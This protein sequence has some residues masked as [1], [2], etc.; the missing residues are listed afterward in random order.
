MLLTLRRCSDACQ[1]SWHM[2]TVQLMTLCAAAAGLD[3]YASHKGGRYI[4]W[5][6]ARGRGHPASHGQCQSRLSDNSGRD[7]CRH[8]CTVDDLLVSTA[9]RW[10]KPSWSCLVNMC[11]FIIYLIC[12]FTAKWPLF[13]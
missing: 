5:M 11:H 2:V 12:W 13:L 6:G 8:K 4:H 3:A 9:T 10:T 1:H 7:R